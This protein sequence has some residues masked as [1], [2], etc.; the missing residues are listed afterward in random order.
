MTSQG[1]RVLDANGKELIKLGYGQST[2]MS[3]YSALHGE[4]LPLA[5]MALSTQFWSSDDRFYIGTT[6]GEAQQTSWRH[7]TSA[8]SGGEFMQFSSPTGRIVV[9][10]NTM[11][12]ENGVLCFAK[13][14]ASSNPCNADGQSDSQIGKIDTTDSYSY[15]HYMNAQASPSFEMLTVPANK[16]FYINFTVSGYQTGGNPGVALYGN[17]RWMMVIPI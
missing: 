9:I 4:L 10:W 5:S 17:K 14:T 8:K 2:G 1:F 11:A 13:V 6:P 16:N 12:T 15:A 7:L 3:V